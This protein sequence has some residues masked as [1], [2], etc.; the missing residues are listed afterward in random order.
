MIGDA[1]RRE[2]PHAETGADA[3]ALHTLSVV[4]LIVRHGHDEL[5]HTRGESLRHRPDA[6][7]MDEHARL[8]QQRAERRVLDG[9]NVRGQ[10]LRHLFGFA[11]D[12]NSAATDSLHCLCRDGKES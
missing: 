12:K 10:M 9:E 11:R 5:R 8:F 3:E 1:L 7:V 2:L 4:R 6:S